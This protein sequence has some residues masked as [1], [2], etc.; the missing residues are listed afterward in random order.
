MAGRRTTLSAAVDTVKPGLTAGFVPQRR[1]VRLARTA[2]SAFTSRPPGRGARGRLRLSAV[3]AVV[4]YRLTAAARRLR[5]PLCAR[6]GNV[7]PAA[8][9]RLRAFAGIRVKDPS[10]ADRLLGPLA[11]EPPGLTAERIGIWGGGEKGLQCLHEPADG[12]AGP[13]KLSR[14]GEDEPGMGLGA[15]DRLPMELHEV[16]DVLGDDGSSLG[17]G[18][19]Q[20]VAV[21]EAVQL[22]PL[23]R[24]DHVV[25]PLPELASDLR[26]EV[27]VQQQLHRP[28]SVRSRSAAERSRSAAAAWR[29]R[30]PS[31]S[32]AKAA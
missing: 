23:S 6:A 14:G 5:E 2:P 19:R 15:E 1:G 18:H 16:R 24:C 11:F 31:I 9:S 27:L 25:A 20:Q 7:A 4:I 30:M 26:R 22:G 8:D 32:S 3:I 28:K 29:S 17:R 10:P 13:R 12:T 21:R